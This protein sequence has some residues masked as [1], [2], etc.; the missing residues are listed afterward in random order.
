ML[1]LPDTRRVCRCRLDVN[2]SFVVELSKHAQDGQVGSELLSL[3]GI[4]TRRR[5]MSQGDIA[6]IQVTDWYGIVYRALVPQRVA[7]EHDPSVYRE[8]VA[9]ARATASSVAGEKCE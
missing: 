2:G 6:S 4:W 9:D 1:S 5:P 8:S 3:L 7:L